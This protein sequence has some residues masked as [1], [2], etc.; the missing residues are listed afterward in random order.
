[1]TVLRVGIAC[2]ARSIA[3]PLVLVV[4]ACL[5]AAS[6]QGIFDSVAG[7]VVDSVNRSIGVEPDD[8]VRRLQ[9]D[10]VRVA[11]R[12]SDE[13]GDGFISSTFGAAEEMASGGAGARSILEDTR[14]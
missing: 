1:M 6:A 14:T 8:H 9:I 11:V 4:V 7:T 12:G 10:A 13:D 3:L 2:F 5:P